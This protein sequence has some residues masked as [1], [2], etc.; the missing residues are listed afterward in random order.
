LCGRRLNLLVFLPIENIRGNRAFVNRT[1]QRFIGVIDC[2][3][4]A[5]GG[6]PEEARCHDDWQDVRPTC[7]CGGQEFGGS[8]FAANSEARK[9]TLTNSKATRAEESACSI[10]RFHSSPGLASAGGGTGFPRGLAREEEAS[11]LVSH[12]SPR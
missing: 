11:N 7:L 10:S 4:A 3:E 12:L 5:Q 6:P 1:I 2:L 9:L 8:S